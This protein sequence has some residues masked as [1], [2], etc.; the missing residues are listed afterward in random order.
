MMSD[1]IKEFSKDEASGLIYHGTPSQPLMAPVQ[2]APV[3]QQSIAAPVA[4]PKLAMPSKGKASVGVPD[5]TELVETVAK[6]NKKLKEKTPAPEAPSAINGLVDQVINNWKPIALTTAAT[7]ALT[8]APSLASKGVDAISKRFKERN[9]GQGI[10]AVRIE[11]TFATDHE[12]RQA[13]VLA[14]K[15][16]PTLTPLQ[17]LEQRANDIRAAVQA[18]KVAATPVIPNVETAVA[19]GGNVTKAVQQDVAKLTDETFGLKTGSGFPA[20]Q[21]MAPPVGDIKN[22]RAPKGGNLDLSKLPSDLAFVPGFGPGLNTARNMIS[23]QGAQ[24]LARTQGIPWGEDTASRQRLKE[25]TESIFG[26]DLPR[27]VRKKLDIPMPENTKGISMKTGLKSL[28]AIG[29]VMALTDIAKAETP[30]QRR[31]A[32]TEAMLGLLPPLAHIGAAGESEADLRKLHELQKYAQQIGG[33]RG[34]APPSAYSQGG[35]NYNSPR[36]R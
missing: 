18:Q 2:Q 20:Q 36:I 7:V 22:W 12:M 34:I 35:L 21:G 25:F 9:P 15:P 29:A 16:E 27:D 11:P 14:Q 8:K 33:G 4:P 30:Q 28:G 19:T 23:E 5:P 26:P 17:N 1:E 31:Q 6:A 13:E 3:A 32:E 24:H 10:E